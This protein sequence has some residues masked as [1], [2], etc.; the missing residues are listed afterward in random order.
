[1]STLHIVRTLDVRHCLEVLD[2]RG[3]AVLLVQDGV[4]HKN[5]FPCP[6]S[7]SKDDVAARQVES[8]YPQLDYDGIRELML[9]HERAVVW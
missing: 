4:L 3:D 1:M 5:G 7:A 9:A 8:P 2:P 6:V